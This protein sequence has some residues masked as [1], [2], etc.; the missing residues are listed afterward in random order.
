MNV[1]LDAQDIRAEAGVGRHIPDEREFPVGGSSA[2]Q[3]LFLLRYAV[4][5]PSTRNT[6]PWKFSITE[7][8]IDV[9]ADYTRRLPVADPGNRELL[10]SV[11]AA[12][13]NLR[14]AAARFG[15]TCRVH[16]N[17]SGDSERPLAIVSHAPAS[18]DLSV[19]Q[20]LGK[21]F[22]AITRRHTNRQ[23]FLVS[24]VPAAVLDRLQ[25][26]GRGY[27]SSVH[28]STDGRINEIVAELVADADRR[29][30]ADPAYRKD[31]AEWMRPDWTNRQDGLPGAA[32]GAKGIASA[33]TPWA[34][35]VL[36]LG[37]VRAARD[38]NLCLEAP[39]LVAI[40]GE[41]TVPSWLD[42][43]E[44]LE[45]LLLTIALEGM[46]TSYFNM[47]VQVPAL[48]LRLRSTLGLVSWPQLLLRV[49]FCLSDTVPTPRRP[50]DEVLIHTI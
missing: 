12:I 33:L 36:D 20:A 18:R 27:A 44:L 26:A 22:P 28:I 9:F 14:V 35:R 41:D 4:L 5:A 24:R 29:Q 1:A 47:P 13:M 45:R 17:Y 46:Q 50:I 25:S 31:I 11:G 23:P 10:M 39:A 21:I 42:G 15:L 6:Q 34:T 43:G 32:L 37:H 3:S 49:G 8:G 30:L 2:D 7:N 19:D 38:K 48:R 16:Y 40:A